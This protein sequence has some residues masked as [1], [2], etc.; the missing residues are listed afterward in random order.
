[1]MAISQSPSGMGSSYWLGASGNMACNITSLHV[2]ELGGYKCNKYKLHLLLMKAI[3]ESPVC[4][5]GGR[6]I[7]H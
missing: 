5:S 4:R 2:K 7:S 3:T 1:M 6:R